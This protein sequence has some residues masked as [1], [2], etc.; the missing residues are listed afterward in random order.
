MGIKMKKA[1]SLAVLLLIGDA[2]AETL[3]RN[4]H[5]KSYV[6]FLDGDYEDWNQDLVQDKQAQESVAE[7]EKQIGK[8]L[9]TDSDTMTAALDYHNK[10]HFD[11]DGE[12]FAKA[13]MEDLTPEQQFE[14]G[15]R[16]KSPAVFKEDK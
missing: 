14:E 3:Y 11:Q 8:E 12:T 2:S 1:L 6:Q 4:K 16:R 15:Q 13:K 7:A 5:G 10:L 9:K